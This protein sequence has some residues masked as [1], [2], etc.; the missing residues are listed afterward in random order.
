[1]KPEFLKYLTELIAADEHVLNDETL[2]DAGKIAHLQNISSERNTYITAAIS[3]DL[4]LLRS[5]DICR[6]EK[7]I[8]FYHLC[9]HDCEICNA[10]STCNQHTIDAITTIRE[11]IRCYNFFPQ[12]SGSE[13]DKTIL[14]ILNEILAFGKVHTT[15][16]GDLCRV[17]ESPGMPDR[18]RQ[19]DRLAQEQIR[20]FARHIVPLLDLFIIV[21]E[22]MFGPEKTKKLMEDPPQ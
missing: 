3:E 2:S 1:M 15:V 14:P 8:Q 10:K 22:R 7:P 13:A 16:S 17:I 11:A 18:E 6:L 4:T 21:S 9:N 20:A 12:M 19:L 5:A